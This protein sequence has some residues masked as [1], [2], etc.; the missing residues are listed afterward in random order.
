MQITYRWYVLKL[1]GKIISP[2]HFERK[3]LG[4]VSQDFWFSSDKQTNEALRFFKKIDIP[5]ER[6][7][8]QGNRD[9]QVIQTVSSV[10]ISLMAGKRASLLRVADPGRNMRALM[11]ALEQVLGYGLSTRAV[12]FESVDVSTLLEKFDV[13]KLIGLKLTN[14]VFGN[15]CVGRME[16]VSK[17]GIE[18]SAIKAL[19]GLSYKYEYAKYELLY[20]ALKGSFSYSSSGL[21]RV[22]GQLS[23]RIVEL[24]EKQL[25]KFC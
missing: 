14:M 20:R 9:V 12:V 7:D 16:F 8:A 11:D 24:L 13:S 5:V 23:G 4:A 19:R 17:N 18:L 25:L 15:D 22:G 2:D 6:I 1:E 21:V 3:A 10:G